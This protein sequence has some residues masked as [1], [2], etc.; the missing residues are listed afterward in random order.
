M[1]DTER[2][3]ANAVVG[4]PFESDE[5]DQALAR[6][7]EERIEEMS[8]PGIN[9][10]EW[11]D[12]GLMAAAMAR[13]LSERVKELEAKVAELEK[14]AELQEEKVLRWEAPSSYERGEVRHEIE[15]TVLG[16]EYARALDFA[17]ENY[18]WM[19]GTSRDAYALG[20][21]RAKAEEA[22]QV[23][24]NRERYEAGQPLKSEAQVADALSVI[25][26]DKKVEILWVS[27]LPFGQ[28]S[29]AWQHV[30]EG[31][32]RTTSATELPKKARLWVFDQWLKR[33]V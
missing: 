7:I 2:R 8:G 28:Y 33:E 32:W 29:V 3:H 20:W 12:A 30:G 21:A 25:Y 31:L 24:T 18:P 26:A 16:R 17:R 14:P 9:R 19:S 11:T 1:G 23:E 27:K 15:K 22:E 4:D 13:L 5:Q 10:W 6:A